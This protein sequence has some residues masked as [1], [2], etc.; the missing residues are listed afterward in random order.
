MQDDIG[1][2]QLES[3]SRVVPAAFFY[4]MAVVAC[5][6][7]IVGGG[8]GRKGPGVNVVEGVVTLDGAALPGATVVFRPVAGGPI[9]AGTTD[10][11]G[12]YVMTT[13]GFKP[14]AGV[15]AGDYAVTIRKYKSFEDEL[16]SRP[17]DPEALAQWEAKAQQLDAKWSA[18][19]G[20][21]F[22]TPKAYASDDTS[23]L[24]A[25]VVPGRNTCD[26]SL[27]GTHTAPAGRSRIP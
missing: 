16:S 20:P 1:R 2:G 24:S 11:T 8:C 9:G 23:G 18:E 4:A 12:R 25:T 3:I 6:A 13:L 15:L 5:L 27:V 17:E 14:G 19:G 7:P 26:F 10:A 21:P 22:I